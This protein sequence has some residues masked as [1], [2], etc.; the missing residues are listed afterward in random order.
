MR[1]FGLVVLVLAET[2]EVGQFRRASRISAESENTGGL[3]PV[4]VGRLFSSKTQ[5][6]AWE[7]YMAGDIFKCDSLC[8]TDTKTEHTISGYTNEFS[9]LLGLSVST[10]L[11]RHFHMN[12]S[13]LLFEPPKC[14]ELFVCKVVSS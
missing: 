12:L 8:E 13:L 7:A 6:Y 1:L 14:F 4:L 5:Q 2:G 3:R 10:R 11:V 9:S